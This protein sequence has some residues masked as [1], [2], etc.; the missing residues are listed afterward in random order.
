MG[1]FLGLLSRLAS[2]GRLPAVKTPLFLRKG[3]FQSVEQRTEN[4]CVVGSIPI[5][6][7]LLIRQLQLNVVA[8]FFYATTILQHCFFFLF[9]KQISIYTGSL[10]YF[11][12]LPLYLKV[13]TVCHFFDILED[14]A[15]LVSRE[16]LFFQQFHC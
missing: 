11:Y 14:V 16:Q 7:T 10:V 5:I 12:L 15:D 4:P 8:A 1:Q 13:D 6:T 3:P 2:H 9:K